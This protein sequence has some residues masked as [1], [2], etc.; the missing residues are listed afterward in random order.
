M[1]SRGSFGAG[2]LRHSLL[3]RLYAIAGVQARLLTCRPFDRS[4]LLRDPL[5]CSRSPLN[6]PPRSRFG[7]ERR[8][9]V[10]L[11][12][13]S[14]ALWPSDTPESGHPHRHA[15]IVHENALTYDAS[16][17]EYFVSPRRA[18]LLSIQRVECP[19]AVRSIDSR[20]Q[21]IAGGAEALT[22]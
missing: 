12:H 9:R 5:L 16:A 7:D 11:R 8:P 13:G 3:E 17:Q 20:W 10:M 2:A 14:F 18:V 4:G 19:H 21:S 6:S 1:V 22:C 15:P